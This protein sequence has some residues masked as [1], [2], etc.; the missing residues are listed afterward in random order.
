M[1][2]HGTYWFYA[3]LLVVGIA[4]VYFLIPETN[5]KSLE[6]IEE[7]ATQELS[8]VTVLSNSTHSFSR[9]F[10]F[11][12]HSSETPLT[13]LYLS[14]NAATSESASACEV[15]FFEAASA[16]SRTLR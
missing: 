15:I 1:G 14:F 5:G 8:S 2:E 12:T 16:A 4:G 10:T 13:L 9:V 7:G 6:Q 3:T 11:F